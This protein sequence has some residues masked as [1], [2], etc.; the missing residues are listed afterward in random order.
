MEIPDNMNSCILVPATDV[1]V[2]PKHWFETNTP[3]IIAAKHAW[4]Q[5]FKFSQ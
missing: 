4:E 3:F 2:T 5:D 1:E